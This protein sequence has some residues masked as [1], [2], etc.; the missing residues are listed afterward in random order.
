MNMS[1]GQKKLKVTFPSGNSY[2][3]KYPVDTMVAVLNE[4]GVD[5]FPDIT[6]ESGGRR[7]ITQ[8]VHPDD[9]KYKKQICD[10]WWYINKLSNI[11]YKVYQITEIS[12]CL[13]L[14]LTIESGEGLEVTNK[15]EGKWTKSKKQKLI[16]IFKEDGT[17]IDYESY[18]DVY[19]ACIYK[20]GANKIARRSFDW[21]GHPLVTT[22]NITGKRVQIDT[23]KWIIMP[24]TTGDAV[25]LLTLIALYL[26]IQ[27]EIKT[28]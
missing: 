20:I 28:I 7:I 6:L 21:K 13:S 24:N 12:R 18:R 3:Y 26:D 27:L 1:Q 22:T 9:D 11:D 25:K 8:E 14:D 16:V 10:D 15:A 17:C 5:R 19:L 4:I 2:C 23:S